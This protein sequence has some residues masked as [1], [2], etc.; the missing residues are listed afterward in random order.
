MKLFSHLA[1]GKSYLLII[2]GIVNAT[3]SAKGEKV[4]IYQNKE[5]E[6]FV[7]EQK[8]F[9]QKFEEVPISDN[10]ICRCKDGTILKGQE[11]YNKIIGNYHVA[12]WNHY[13]PKTENNGSENTSISN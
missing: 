2:E 7:R 9:Y 3:N 13:T 5:G 12:G 11:A 8:E 10:L 6:V 1:S 4:V